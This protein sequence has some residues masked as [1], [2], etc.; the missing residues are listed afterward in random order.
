[1]GGGGA[2][3]DRDHLDHVRQR[4]RREGAQVGRDPGEERIE[5]ADAQL[6]KKAN[7]ILN[8]LTLEKFDR[9]SAEFCALEFSSPTLVASVLDLI[10]DKAQN[11]SHFV[12]IYAELCKK[13]SETPMAGLGET[14]KGKKFRRLLLERCQAEFER[15]HASTIAELEQLEADERELKLAKIRKRYIGH[16]FFIGALYKQELLKESIMHHCVQELFGDPADPDAEKLECLAKLLTT[17]GKQLDAAAVRSGRERDQG[18]RDPPRLQ[19][20]V[21]EDPDGSAQGRR[22]RVQL[23]RERGLGPLQGRILRGVR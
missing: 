3:A 6:L 15:D 5:D 1:V 21:Q 18:G 4:H 20:A 8:K 12:G 23:P 7:S 17:I 10:V 14:E 9:L 22:A 16:M 13:L 19:E 11:E 2:E